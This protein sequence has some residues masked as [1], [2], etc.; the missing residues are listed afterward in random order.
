MPETDKMSIRAVITGR[1]ERSAPILVNMYLQNNKEILTQHQG[2]VLEIAPSEPLKPVSRVEDILLVS[3]SMTLFLFLHDIVHR[4][5]NVSCRQ[6]SDHWGNKTSNRQA[7]FTL[8]LLWMLSLHPR[9][10]FAT[11]F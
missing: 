11:P 7:P 6:E 1:L 9:W 3:K 5:D 2:T 10:G 4:D 8:T